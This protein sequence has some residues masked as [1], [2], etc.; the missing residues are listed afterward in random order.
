MGKDQVNG[1]HA[2]AYPYVYKLGGRLSGEH[3]IGAKKVVAMEKVTNPV[4]LNMMR[5][6]KRA[7]DPKNILNPGKVFN[8]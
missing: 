3:G 8:V 7:L 6:I 5:S 2:I 4:E 1:F